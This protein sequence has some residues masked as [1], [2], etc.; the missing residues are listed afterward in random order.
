[1]NLYEYDKQIELLL[2]ESIDPET[3]EI[4]SETAFDLFEKMEGD[5]KQKMLNIGKYIKSESYKIDAFKEEKKRLESRM[6][7]LVNKTDRLKQYLLDHFDE[8]IE[9][10]QISISTRKSQSVCIINSEL[11]PSNFIKELLVRSIDKTGL[12]N[13]LKKN[14]ESLKDCAIIETKFNIQLK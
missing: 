6:S 12:K 8:K 9:D 14:P 2:Q 13:E 1:M 10:E 3:G 4:K 11:V 5:K 7:V